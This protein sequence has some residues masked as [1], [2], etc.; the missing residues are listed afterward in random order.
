MRRLLLRLYPRVWRERY[1]AE[2]SDLIDETGLSPRAVIDVARG[3]A[4]EWAGETRL[5]LEGGIS[6][7]IGPAYRHPTSWAV[8]GLLVLAPTLSFVL[9]SMLTY[10]FGMTGLVGL[11]EPLNRWLDGQRLLELAL[12]A[13]PLIAL[14][15]AAV[16]LLRV[17]LRKIES[18]REAVLGVRLRG[19]NVAIGLLAVVIGGVLVGHILVESVLGLGS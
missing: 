6:M 19:L 2:L 13:A 10:Q 7:V 12:V 11:M 1:G 4:R 8:V 17:E 14:L 18:G 5:A 9:L 15:L 16:P 3:A